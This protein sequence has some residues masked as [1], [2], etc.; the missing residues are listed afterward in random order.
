VFHACVLILVLGVTCAH[1]QSKAE[2]TAEKITIV[3]ADGP[4]VVD[5]VSETSDG[6]WYK[7]GNMFS[8]ANASFAST[9]RSLRLRN[10]L[11]QT[12]SRAKE[13]GN[14]PTPARSRSFF[15]ASSSGCCR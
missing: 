6:Y 11:P 12:S 5:E 8:I 4:L 15:S 13:S 7:R 10:R 3:L 2:P 9:A 1:A 14:S